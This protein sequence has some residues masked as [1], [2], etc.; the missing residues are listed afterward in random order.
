[1]KIKRIEHIAIA[2]ND[3]KEVAGLLQDKFG[4]DLEYEEDRSEERL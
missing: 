2:V 1:M 3:L 4:I